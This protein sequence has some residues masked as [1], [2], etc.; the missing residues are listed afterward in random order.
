M[1]W[2]RTRT[3]FAPLLAAALTW[4][5]AASAHPHGWIDIQTRLLF[6]DAGRVTGIEQAWLF[7]ELYSA[8][9]LEEFALDGVP[10]EEGLEELGQADIAALAEFDYFTNLKQDGRKVALA[11]VETFANGLA[12][13][14]IWMRFE[15][16]L[17]APLDVDA[18]EVRYAV[19][20][21][22]YFIE[23]MHR[24]EPPVL[25]EGRPA[26]GFEVIAPDPPSEMVWLAAALD[27]GESG[28]DG[29]GAYF[30]EWVVV[31]CD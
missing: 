15:V 7:D 30:A 19:Y 31:T 10:V 18:G 21:P 9:I 13:D 23:I 3:A 1:S 17:V 20:D 14:R 16:P 27:R 6:D 29:L 26:C 12:A 25:L 2:N 8:F 24:G 11:S 22:T 28:G 4:P 5:V